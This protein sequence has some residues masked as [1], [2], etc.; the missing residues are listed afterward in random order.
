[1]RLV[2]VGLGPWGLD[3]AREVLPA[4]PDIEVVARVDMD[5]AARIKA[6]AALGSGLGEAH[7]SLEAVPQ[8]GSA[9]A[10]LVTVPLSSHAA[11]ARAALER[12][13]HVLVEK[14]FCETVAEAASLADLAERR[15][16]VLM[17]NQNY[18]HFPASL[19]AARLV[20]ERHFGGVVSVDVDFRR[21]GAA[22]GYRYWHLAQPLLGDMAIHHFDLMRMVLGSEPIEVSARAWTMPGTRFSGPPAAVA[23]VLF[24]GGVV[25]SY[26]GSWISH[27][28]PTPYGGLWRMDCETGEIRWTCRGAGADRLAFDRLEVRPDGGGRQ[29][30]ELAPLPHADRNGCLA[31]FAE[32]VAS[33]RT[34]ARFSSGRDNMGSLALMA[35]TIRSAAEGGRVVPIAELMPQEEEAV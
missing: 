16:L 21:N 26:R 2:Q 25:V 34:P 33:G 18:R 7:A 12:G 5:P 9:D 15:G 1:M 20:A 29:R 4:F 27:D 3:W 8:L 6:A 11:V 31:A 24:P 32:A 28:E 23:T 13:K 17:V 30:V 14:P 35:A 19:A 22:D 10:V